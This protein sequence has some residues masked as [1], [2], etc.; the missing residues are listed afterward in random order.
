MIKVTKLNGKSYH[1]N[2]IFIEQVESN[3]DTTITMTNASKYVVLESEQEVLKAIHNF[4]KSIGIL[5]SI[6]R[7]DC[8]D[9]E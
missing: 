7:E 3:P 4:Y 5:G 9:E 6:E 2:A 1:L 8:D